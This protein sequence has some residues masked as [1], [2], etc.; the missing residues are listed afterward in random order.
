MLGRIKLRRYQLQKVA[1]CRRQSW[2]GKLGHCTNSPLFKF[3]SCNPYWR[4]NKLLV[5]NEGFHLNFRRHLYT[6]QATW[7]I[8]LDGILASNRR[9][10]YLRCSWNSENA[11]QRSRPQRRGRLSLPL[12]HSDHNKSHSWPDDPPGAIHAVTTLRTHAHPPWNV[13]RPRVLLC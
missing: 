13:F 9:A 8:M 4:G 2:F 7:T 5:H 3:Q 1:S 6:S 11:V 12:R 10:R